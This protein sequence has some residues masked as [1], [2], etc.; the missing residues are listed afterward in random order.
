V[1]PFRQILL[2]EDNPA[3]VELI[4]ESLEEHCV[5]CDLLVIGSG[6]EACSF[7]DG[8]AAG[9]HPCPDL[10]VIDLNLPRKPGVEVLAYLRE[11][12]T[13]QHIPVVVLTSS[14]SQKDKDAVARFLPSRYIQKPSRLEDFLEI[15]AEF[16]KL[17]HPSH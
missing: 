6:E 7:F 17:L 3:D 12:K 8:I 16:R 4:R 15:G 14:G 11:K 2:I 5:S 9:Q 10:F 13:C 1:E